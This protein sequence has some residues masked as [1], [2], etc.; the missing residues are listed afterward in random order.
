MDD[1]ES[2][3]FSFSVLHNKLS[4]KEKAYFTVTLDN[5]SDMANFSH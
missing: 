2:I 4:G 1:I 5:T 3:E